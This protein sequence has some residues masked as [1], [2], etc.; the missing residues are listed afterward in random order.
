M[1]C[2]SLKSYLK[3]G[4]SWRTMRVIPA[5]VKRSDMWP[6]VMCFYLQNPVRTSQDTVLQDFLGHCRVSIFPKAARQY[7]QISNYF[8]HILRSIFSSSNTKQLS[9]ERQLD[10]YISL[11]FLVPSHFKIKSTTL[12]II[13][14]RIGGF[15]SVQTFAGTKCIDASTFHYK[16]MNKRP[17]VQWVMN[18]ATKTW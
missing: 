18:S 2:E 12:F 3:S 7:D 8:I 16:R 10:V 17:W 9:N 14:R 5:F 13:S 1:L 4:L 11:H 6:R 15:V